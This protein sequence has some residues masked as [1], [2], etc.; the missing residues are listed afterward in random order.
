MLE[1]VR[2]SVRSGLVTVL[3]GFAACG[4]SERHVDELTDTGGA[5]SGKSPGGQAH[6][7]VITGSGG[8]AA[9]TFGA[10]TGG[11]FNGSGGKA[12]GGMPLGG[13]APVQACPAV[14]LVEPS[15]SPEAGAGQGGAG[16]DASS[17]CSLPTEG[18]AASDGKAGSSG[19][20]GADTAAG[21]APSMPGTPSRLLIDDFED[22]DDASLPLPDGQ[23]FWFVVNDGSGQQFPAPCTLPSLLS[24]PERA[25]ER[26][27]R[28]YGQGFTTQPGGYSLIG[29][30][31]RSGAPACDQSI[32]A[33]AF[34]GVEFWARGTG[35][36]RFFIGTV[37]T[38][39]PADAGI[40]TGTCYDAHGESVMLGPTWQLYR[41]RFDQLIQEGWGSPAGF[42]RS[43]ILGLQWSAKV[44]PFNPTPSAC[45]DFWIDDVAFYAD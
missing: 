9:G 28:T 18:G 26:A 2:L 8:G 32:D 45:F 30:S 20:A 27:M 34:D 13:M 24:E 14:P 7:G 29:L 19:E 37:A 11:A 36:V 40:C 22:G 6:G 21:G 17:W 38:H 25:S 35:T 43:K 10:P 12:Y 23:G 3:F 44:A 39:P 16:G 1:A 15:C 31:V 5:S 41:L 42:D 4:I 33:S